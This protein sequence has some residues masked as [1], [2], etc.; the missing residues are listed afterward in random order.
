[1]NPR[2]VKAS[3]RPPEVIAAALARLLESDASLDLAMAF[4]RGE[5]MPGV[6]ARSE[7]HRRVQRSYFPGRSGDV[8]VVLK[9]LDLTSEKKPTDLLKDE[10]STTH[11]SPHEYDRFVPLIVS[12]P[13][14]P[15][16]PRGEAV[17]PQATAAIF[18]RLLGIRPP[19]SAEFPV[20][21]SL[22]KP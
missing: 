21:A 9:P 3:G 20:P 12:G 6:P 16:G 14:I 18:A 8:Y 1:L 19:G 22:E 15:G 2:L 5:L 11:G 17:T 10:S 13:D 4:S 7:L